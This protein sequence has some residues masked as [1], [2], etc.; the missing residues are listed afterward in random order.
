MPELPEVAD[1]VLC[2]LLTSAMCFSGGFIVRRCLPMF[3][4]DRGFCCQFCYIVCWT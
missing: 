2:R 1:R 3:A 4:V